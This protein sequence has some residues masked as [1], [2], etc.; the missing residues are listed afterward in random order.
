MVLYFL[1]THGFSSCILFLLFFSVTFKS[2]D[3]QRVVNQ[4]VT[5]VKG[6]NDNFLTQHIRGTLCALCTCYA[7]TLLCPLCLSVDAAY[8]FYR[9]QREEQSLKRRGKSDM[10]QKKKRRHERKLRV[11]IPLL[12]ATFSTFPSMQEWLRLCNAQAKHPCVY[13]CML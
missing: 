7:H 4:L 10:K 13:T 12:W 9:S 11:R 5:E 3:N 2:S 8:R 6:L 1:C